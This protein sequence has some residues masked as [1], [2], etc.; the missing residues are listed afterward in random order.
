M[1]FHCKNSVIT[2]RSIL[3]RW[4]TPSFF[5]A[6]RRIFQVSEGGGG[7][8][9]VRAVCGDGDVARMASGGS[10]FHYCPSTGCWARWWCCPWP[11]VGKS[12]FRPPVGVSFRD[13]LYFL[14]IQS[15]ESFWNSL[16]DPKN[17]KSLQSW[18]FTRNCFKL[19]TDFWSVSS[20][21]KGQG[22]LCQLRT[23]AWRAGNE[24][25]KRQGKKAFSLW[26]QA[27]ETFVF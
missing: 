22:E 10:T 17:R 1:T 4:K 21:F 15:Q 26:T 9:E 6:S 18:T 13:L 24:L 23:W 20:Q 2:T 8:A 27:H 16:L 25:R 11:W 19:K 14:I 5:S 12:R 3:A 7:G